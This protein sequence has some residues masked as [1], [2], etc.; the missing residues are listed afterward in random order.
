MTLSSKRVDA[1]TRNH[2]K[3]RD[4]KAKI[5]KLIKKQTEFYT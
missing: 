1:L 2:I 3:K 4:K 5:N